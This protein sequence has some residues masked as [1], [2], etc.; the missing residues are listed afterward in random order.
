MRDG[1]EAKPTVVTPNQQEAERLLSRALLTRTHFV[2]AVQR[3]RAMGPE[4]V[5]LSLGSRGAIAAFDDAVVEA[6]PP[7]V[8]AVCPI[9][10]GDAMA[11]AYTWAMSE[12]K[13]REDALRWAVAAGTATAR[14]P[15]MQFAS[16]VQS[17]EVY[18]RVEVRRV[19]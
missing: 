19:E 16:K 5:L 12:G 8:D 17:E 14:L 7:R 3:I 6:V 4:C 11:A 15:G 13:P 18:R 1:V 10:A 2:D 9:G